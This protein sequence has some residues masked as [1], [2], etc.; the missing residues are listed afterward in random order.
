MAPILHCIRHGEGYHNLSQEKRQIHDPSLTEK[1]EEQCRASCKAFPYHDNIEL[2]IVSPLRRTIQ[3]AL[4]VLEPEF[5]RGMVALA[6]PDAQE[7]SADPCGRGSDPDTLEAEYP[8]RVDFR[9][10]KDSWNTKEGRW[11]VKNETLEKRTRELRQF[12]RARPEKEIALV[13]HGEIMYHFEEN[14]IDKNNQPHSKSS[15]EQV[16]ERPV[17]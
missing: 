4:L 15:G 13:C 9:H 3:T 7:V 11:E 17:R 2:I 12:I 1:G 5:K 16:V 10:V 6:M 8:K 14:L